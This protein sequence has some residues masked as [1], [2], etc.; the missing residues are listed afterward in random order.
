M[1]GVLLITKFFL[2]WF[3][4]QKTPRD[5]SSKIIPDSCSS[6]FSFVDSKELE[7]TYLPKSFSPGCRSSALLSFWE[8]HLKGFISHVNDC[9]LYPLLLSS[10]GA[11]SNPT[12]SGAWGSTSVHAPSRAASSPCQAWT[13]NR[14]QV[15]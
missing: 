5:L 7:S 12:R 14:I 11:W 1:E 13:G 3:I 9:H 8:V 6:V 2:L 10:G 4:C 15:E